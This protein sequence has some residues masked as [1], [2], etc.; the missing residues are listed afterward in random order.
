MG[1]YC[2]PPCGALSWVSPGGSLQWQLG[3]GA[4]CPGPAEVTAEALLRCQSL[5]GRARAWGRARPRAC[6]VPRPRA[7]GQGNPNSQHPS[8]EPPG[9]RPPRSEWQLGRAGLRPR[10]VARA[11]RPAAVRPP[12]QP[13]KHPKEPG[14]SSRGRPAR[15]PAT[16]PPQ[17][18]PA[19]ALSTSPDAQRQLGRVQVHHVVPQE[20]V[21]D[22]HDHRLE[23]HLGA[24]ASRGAALA[25]LGPQHRQPGPALAQPA[26]GRRRWLASACALPTQASGAGRGGAPRRAAP[27]RPAEPALLRLRRREPRAAPPPSRQPSYEGARPAGGRSRNATS[28]RMRR[29]AFAEKLRVSATRARDFARNQSGSFSRGLSANGE[30]PA[31]LS[32][33]SPNRVWRLCAS[34]WP[35]WTR[36]RL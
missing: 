12:E 13:A 25:G 23:H 32:R 6:G 30:A 35:A 15:L 1:G 8:L 22:V 18:S 36:N 10:G 7:R 2:A 26:A 16:R 20:A 11:P 27:R 3:L 19:W 29:V 34:V 14:Y 4:H 5:S 9:G 21:Q 17:G 31:R 28:G 33:G 24:R